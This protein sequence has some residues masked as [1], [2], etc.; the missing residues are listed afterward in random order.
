MERSPDHLTDY[1]RAVCYYT[2]PRV[3]HPVT[4]GL[5]VAYAVCLFE[6]AGALAIGLLF[7]H[8]IWTLSGG[9]ALFAMSLFGMIVFT[10]RAF[11]ND[12]RQRRTLALA[13]GTPDATTPESD[14]PDPFEAHILLCSPLHP[15]KTR[16][17]CLH[18]N[19]NHEYIVQRGVYKHGW[20][21]EDTNDPTSV[22]QVKITHGMRSFLFDAATPRSVVV[23][24]GEQEIAKVTACFALPAP[25]TRIA[26]HDETLSYTLQGGG[27]YCDDRLVG[28][29]YT[30]RQ[31]RYLDIEEPHFNVGILAAFL[32]QNA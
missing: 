15:D 12:W 30:L 8:K 10:A 18:I 9:I 14:L 11:V 13:K 6:A 25:I 7:E 28:R 3:I 31:E 29:I 4:Y 2:L 17:T 23:L 5:I 21:V 27:V 26:L 16:Y 32:T 20:T 24:R 19:E 22:Y 1:E